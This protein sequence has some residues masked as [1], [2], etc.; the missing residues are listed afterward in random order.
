[1]PLQ[2]GEGRSSSDKM[3]SAGVC[4]ALCILAMTLSACG[5]AGG[6][7][8]VDAPRTLSEQQQRSFAASADD[9]LGSASGF[10]ADIL[11]CARSLG[12]P[13]CVRSASAALKT[14]SARSESTITR[15]ASKVMGPCTIA[16]MSVR[17]QMDDPLVALDRVAE[18][19]R[20]ADYAAVNRLADEAAPA[21]KPFVDA[22]QRERTRCA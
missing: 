16:L 19:A 3:R 2:E 14:S 1:M 18:A 4:A 22:V 10:L 13:G 8:T 11:G 6:A 5:G 20:A 7:A 9:F 12:G 21:M 15:L 17:E